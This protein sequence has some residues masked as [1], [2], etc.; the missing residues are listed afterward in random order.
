LFNCS[1]KPIW[2][3]CVIVT[4]YHIRT[5]FY[6]ISCDQVLSG[7]ALAR[8]KKKWNSHINHRNGFLSYPSRLFSISYMP[9]FLFFFEFHVYS[10]FILIWIVWWHE[11]SNQKPLIEGEKKHDQKQQ[12]K[13]TNNNIHNTTQTTNDMPC[14]PPKNPEMNA[15]APERLTVPA[16]LA[17]PVVLGSDNNF[18]YEYADQ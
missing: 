2:S 18:A 13:S 6:D 14:N 7:I 16:P 17:I 9:F 3:D 11:G 1:H 4:L 12:N 15:C 10:N 8:I 5:K